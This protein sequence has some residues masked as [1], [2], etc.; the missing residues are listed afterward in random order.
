MA[1]THLICC[2]RVVGGSPNFQSTADN[3]YWL[4]AQVTTITGVMAV[5]CTMAVR[6]VM[7]VRGA[8]VAMGVMAVSGVMAVFGVMAV[9]GATAVAGTTAFPGVIAGSGTALFHANAPPAP[10]WLSQANKSEQ[11]FRSEAGRL[12]DSSGTTSLLVPLQCRL[13]SGPWRNCNMRVERLGEHWWLE[14]GGRLIEFRHDGHGGVTMRWPGGP[15]RPA[16]SRWQADGCLC[17][18]GICARGAIP[19]D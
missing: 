11:G 14:L 18:D 15:W 19:L 5:R 8:M 7:A 10:P 9:R 1:A 2:T 4:V 6:G 12:P 17:W 16:T 3:G 13:A